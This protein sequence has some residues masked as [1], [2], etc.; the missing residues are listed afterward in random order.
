MCAA[1]LTC[2][3]AWIPMSVYAYDFVANKIYYNIN[4]DG[5]TV[6]VTY[7]TTDY[8]ASYSGS[9]T[10][11]PSV[12][13]GGKTYT[14]T[15]IGESAFRYTY[16]TSVSIPNTVQTI[17][18]YSFFNCP[19]LTSV[20]IPQSVK[21]IV[22]N[23]FLSSFDITSMK[24]AAGNTVYDSRNNCNAIVETS[25]NTIISGCENT[26]IPNDVI[27]IA[28]SAFKG[29]TLNTIFIPKQVKSIGVNA[30]EGYLTTSITVESGNPIYDSRS[31]CNAIIETATNTLV[32]GCKNTVIP[33]TVTA[34]GDF[35]FNDVYYS[36]TAMTIPG[37]VKS[38]GKRAFSC[39][40]DLK[41]IT[42]P[43][44]VQSIGDHAFY[45]CMSMTSASI[46]NAVASIG[47]NAFQ[48]CKKLTNV[49]IPNSVSSLGIYSFSSCDALSSVTLS[50]SLNL[51]DEGTFMSCPALSAITIPNAVSYI[52]AKAF[53]NCNALKTVT[54]QSIVPPVMAH[55]NCF[56]TVAYN[57]AD[58]K[59]PMGA[60]QTYKTTDYWYLFNKM[61]GYGVVITGD[62]NGDG[63]V[64]IQD[65][66]CIVEYILG[67]TPY[68]FIIGQAD[69][70]MNGD[71]EINDVSELIGYL[72]AR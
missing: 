25:K 6:T 36:L 58:L 28:D 49:V 51:I 30:Y 22:G 26:V 50:S 59:V 2:M 1:V 55:S 31:N 10:I 11:P 67:N 69:L 63:I 68:P 52:G 18:K 24:V 38:I 23:P 14:V 43:N 53:D 12:T 71:I 33:N 20:T 41:A 37:S 44:S 29:H 60:I 35:A 32:V 48:Y 27:A 66:S 4:S 47:R 46:G 45:F 5:N 34:I 3:M 17:G 42:I 70:D 39:C 62:V 9:V 13:Y 15:A 57:N 65:V 64:D 54:C 61:T 19:D 21:K 72:L 7:K 56:S 16:I 40:Y 8:S